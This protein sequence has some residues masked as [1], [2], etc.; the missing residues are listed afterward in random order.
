MGPGFI[1][2]SLGILGILGI[3]G[4]LSLAVWLR[5]LRIVFWL[6]GGAVLLS[7]NSEEPPSVLEP[8]RN[9]PAS[10]WGRSSAVEGKPS[11]LSVQS[12]ERSLPE[13]ALRSFVR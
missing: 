6:S 4:S 1:G 9:P 8:N 5:V 2:F 7:S 12:E 3:T 11:D 13:K 10:R